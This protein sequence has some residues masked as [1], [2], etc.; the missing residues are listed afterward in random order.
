MKLYSTKDGAPQ[1]VPED[2][3]LE[4]LQSGE[5]GLPQGSTVP[6]QHESGEVA[7]VPIEQLQQ[8][9]DKGAGI[10]SQDAL[11]EAKLQ[12][13]YGG[14][15]QQAITAVEHGLGSAT[16]GISQ[17][18]EAAVLGNA[19][20]QEKRHQANPLTSA[21][22]DIGGA[23]VPLLIPG[24]DV[25]AGAE[26]AN[27][28]GTLGRAISA[29]ARGVARVG[30]G[31]ESFIR[32]ALDAKDTDSFVAA[33]AKNVA[34]KGAG[35]AIEGGGIGASQH[36]TEEM[37][38]D[39][40]ANGESL[41]AA[42]GHGMLLGLGAGAALATGGQLSRAVLGKLSPY[43]RGL[44]EEGIRA[45]APG[46]TKELEA[47]PGGVR[48]ASRRMLDDD[49][50]KFG[51]TAEDVLPRVQKAADAARQRMD[52]LLE[53]ADRAGAEGPDVEAMF[54]RAEAL[55]KKGQDAPL[56]ALEAVTGVPS[57][58]Q[59]AARGLDRDALTF[60]AKMPLKTAAELNMAPA[61][62]GVWGEEIDAAAGK[63][64]RK[65]GGAPLEEWNDAKL[66]A[67]QYSIIGGAL[68][69]RIAGAE[70]HGSF[71]KSMGLGNLA[72]LGVMGH[73]AAIPHALP[74]VATGM[75]ANWARKMA[76]ERGASSAMVALDKLSALHG[77]ERAVQRVDRNVARGL[78]GAFGREG[79]AELRVRSVVHPAGEEPFAARVAAVQRAMQNP[80]QAASSAVASLVD[81]AP[82][83]AKA[84]EM[85][86]VKATQ[87]LAGLIP[88]SKHPP[89]ITPQFDR[90]HTAS[91]AEKASFN[92]AF[93]VVHDPMVVLKSIQ[94]GRLTRDHVKAIA[95]VYPALY[96]RIVQAAQQQLADLKHPLTSVQKAQLS[97]LLGRPQ[98]V[99]ATRRFQQTY[100][101][102]E[103]NAGG[104]KTQQ[105][106]PQS[107]NKESNVW[108]APKRPLEAT[109]RVNA[110]DVG[111]P[112]GT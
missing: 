35:A 63:A 12:K 18:L 9:L 27:A 46:A 25:A 85:S 48:A 60:G 6:I 16:F 110:L 29:P 17:G 79:R 57:V 42:T 62:R 61:L 69:K 68:E 107:K 39:P 111:R 75:A 28:I 86:S 81:H 24:A 50:V 53:V 31:V 90:P 97:T 51:D 87:Y 21:V 93:D 105:Q 36:L 19:A 4:A 58:E 5:Y 112:R 14:L 98:D 11:Q 106:A 32:G 94:D 83:T 88:K 3:V 1:E 30:E 71:L 41:L 23:A 78:E 101:M 99:D 95:A 96:A 84:F 26:E 13:E 74:A 52:G 20:E 104:D 103:G 54:K 2:V 102:Q 55:A 70:E 108:H 73:M 65:L 10:I 89:S 67:D 72:S 49:A 45:L 47:L 77:I 76:S 92:R 15:G 56:K 7:E 100:A 22:A 8:H 91:Q 44:S 80:M 66:A 33:L 82:S 34:A 38:G 40:Q 109:S 37:L 43:I 64:M 59:A